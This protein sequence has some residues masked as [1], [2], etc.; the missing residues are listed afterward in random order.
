MKWNQINIL[1][2]TTKELKI[3]YCP[4]KDSHQNSFRLIFIGSV[5]NLCRLK[6]EDENRNERS[7][8]VVVDHYTSC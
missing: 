3:Y 1:F 5:Y 7:V 6:V 2:L 8:P 4:L